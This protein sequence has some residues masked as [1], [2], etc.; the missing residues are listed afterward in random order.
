MIAV[1][2]GLFC[3]LQR[4][5]LEDQSVITRW[6]ND[7]FLR[8][9]VFDPGNFIGDPDEQEQAWIEGNAE[10]FGADNLVLIAKRNKD[11]VPLGLFIL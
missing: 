11:D 3:Y 4:P 2:Q 1:S 6:L 8:E 9:T 7:P 10:L 5:D